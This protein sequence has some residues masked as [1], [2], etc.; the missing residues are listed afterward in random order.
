MIAVTGGLGFIGNELVRQLLALNSPVI[1][2]DNRNRTAPRI[3]DLNDVPV[4]EWEITEYE[5]IAPLFKEQKVETVFH[6]AAIHYIPECNSNPERTL[7]V[8]VE[9]TQTILRAAAA[10]KVRNVVFASSGAVYADSLGPLSESSPVSPVDIYGWS[11]FFGE[12]LCHLNSQGHDLPIV[13]ARLFN[14]Y[15]P[16]ETN[17]HIIPEVLE[18]LTKGN[19]LQLGNITTIRDYIHTVDCANALI[20]LSKTKEKGVTT[21]N[22]A[23]GKGYSVK[24]MIDQIGVLATRKIEVVTDKSRIRLVD[25][26]SQV[27]DITRLKQLTGWQPEIAL[28]G[29]LAQ[30]LKFEGLI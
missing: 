26:Q 25:K 14:N 9:G 18:Q 23:T 2:V 21:V 10:A 8:N 27:A 30:L 20:R 6:M 17:P 28:Q 13:V 11:K 16:R 3:G 19:V 24:D 7:R 4:F 29:G 15:G 12:K 1:I 22:V 5:K